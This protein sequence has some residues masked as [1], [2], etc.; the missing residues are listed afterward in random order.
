M[1][2]IYKRE[3][4]TFFTTVTGW[5][6][7]AAH[8]CLAGLYFFAINLLSGYSNVG[9]SFSSILFLL[10]L[11][12]P[13]L[14]MRMLAEERK[15]KT[16]QLILT[17]P[18]SI[19]GIVAGKYLAMATVFTLPVAVMAL[20]PLILS[21]YGTVPMGESYTALLAYYLFGLTCLAIGLFI[22]SITESQIIAA[23]LSFA[24][25]FVGYMMSS[26][27]G[28]ISQTGNLLTKILNA[29]NFTDRL[30]A[31]VEGTLNLKSVLYFVTLI[32]VF[33][34]LTVQSIQKRRY[35][36]SV[37]TLQIG[38][39]SS[40]MIALV[41][42]IAVFLN[43]GF[44][45]L[46]DRYTKIDVTSQK[47][48]TLTQTTKNLVKNLSED[49]T[50]YVI[51]SESSQDET[52]QQTL[53]S[54][55][56]LSDHIKLVYK[57]PV[58]SPDFYK[59]YTD[60]ISVN[61]MIVESAQRFKVINYNNIYEYDYDYSNYSSSVSGYDAEG[62]L[63][64]AIA[65]VTSDSTSVVYELNGHGEASLDS[66]FE[67]GVKKEN[68]DLADLTL[69]KEDS[70]PDD[71]NGVLILSPTND[72]NAEDADKL[73]AYLNNGGKVLI[74]T[75]YVD[76]FSE[77][78]PNLTKVLSEFGLSIGDGL[79]VEQDN[80]RMYQNPIYLLPNVSSD[81]LTNGV[82][83]KSYDYIMMPYAQPIL[84]KE[85]DGVTLTTLLTTSEKAYSK[86]DL[87]QSSDVKKTEDDAQGP[88]TVGVKAVKTLASGE[89]AQLILYSSSYLFTE[90]ANQYTMDNNLTLFTNA[91][92]TMARESESISIPTKSMAST[93][94]TV[95]TASAVRYGI[96][97][98][99]I[100]PI[101]LLAAGI[102]IWAR[103][104][105][106]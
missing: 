94:A 10:L 57:D 21:R 86:T 70:V 6:F 5:L 23:V 90:S 56:E 55:A 72:L 42:A 103:R 71:A 24:L 88:F 46:P 14:S 20:F 15:Q 48:Y 25:L 22:S 75:S 7:I 98:M 60:S 59:D 100:L 78:M 31:M 64:S 99:G 41:V 17:S 40:G 97:L 27:T 53:K 37:K 30:D 43:L 8:I 69:L 105:K 87:N 29:Y 91:I 39:Y 38:A 1:T 84:T 101:G 74:S 32:I 81:S 47:L 61:S 92:S 33:L 52:L 45:A 28:L 82:Y 80:A 4:K 11:S 26:I 96:L 66:S 79:I 67:D 19:G 106:R 83:G 62:Q 104:R 68:V 76:R 85:K 73:V 63:T 34:F 54:Y 18:V 44:S 58:V 3:L 16:D 35:Q 93:Y 95:P 12:T 2:A 77:E 49:V 51:N 65:Y 13:I 102:I 36:V 9:Q 89:E 50:I